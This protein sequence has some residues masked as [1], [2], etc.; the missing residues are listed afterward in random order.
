MKAL[1]KSFWMMALMALI[2]SGFVTSSLLGQALQQPAGGNN[3]VVGPTTAQ[4]QTRNFPA[5]TVDD[6]GSQLIYLLDTGVRPLDT[7]PASSTSPGAGTVLQQMTAAPFNL[8]TADGSAVSAF[9]NL[10][11]I[12]NT[13]PTSAVTVHFRYFSD[14]CADVLDFLVVLTCNDVL[15]FD[16]FNFVV[17]NTGGFNVRNRL[18]GPAITISGVSI[19]PIPVATFNSGRFLLLATASGVDNDGDSFA[20][21]QFPS[22]AAGDC[23]LG[24]LVGT[25]TGLAAFSAAARNNLNALNAAAMS[26]NWL[27]GSQTIA[28]AARFNTDLSADGRADQ[29]SY[30]NKAWARPAVDL[31]GDS[32]GVYPDQDGA[33][34]TDGQI[35]TGS[36][37]EV[38]GGVDEGGVLITGFTNT[39]ALRGELNS[40]RVTIGI[41][42]SG[43]TNLTFEDT[44]ENA[45]GNPAVAAVDNTVLV[46]SGAIAWH[47][48]FPSETTAGAPR[49]G[50]LPENQVLEF[51]SV[52]D[53]YNG[54]R[55]A[56]G[57]DRA[58]GVV[59]ARSHFQMDIY[60]NNEGRLGVASILLPISPPFAG[61]A[62]GLGIT[63][64]CIS[65]GLLIQDGATITKTGTVTNKTTDGRLRL[66]DLNTIAG[67]DGTLVVKSHIDNPVAANDLSAGWIRFNRIRTRLSSYAA[68]VAGYDGT[69]YPV[70]VTLARFNVGFEGFGAGWWL[71]SVRERAGAIP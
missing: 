22:G 2:V 18:F 63:V 26:F 69:L 62:T 13:H 50:A 5:G 25:G 55:T 49:E 52:A 57:G 20:E 35:L 59:P 53:D 12:T 4:L 61:T 21:I 29:V 16:P 23:I 17:P 1:H 3:Q 54:S 51:I 30:G 37:S 15:M 38:L 58:Y 28:I 34:I 31:V 47:V 48:V 44:Y 6:P 14:M 46:F 60:D 66:S 11:S 71:S 19:P 67:A 32:V 65:V 39:L 68:T 10:I 40:G 64:D 56:G 27:V 24:S 43:D 70:Y 45:V 33:A 41:D 8:G 42:H 9:A 7:T 36:E